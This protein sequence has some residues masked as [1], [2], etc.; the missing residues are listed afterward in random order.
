[1]H[2]RLLRAV[3]AMTR[4]WLWSLVF[5]LAARPASALESFSREPS[6]PVLVELS[7]ARQAGARGCIDRDALAAAVETR[8]G[9]NVFVPSADAD[10]RA[11]VTASIAGRGFVLVLILQNRSGAR[12]GVRRLTTRARHCSALDDSL[13][14]VLALAVDLRRDD[15]RLELQPTQSSAPAEPPAAI[16][17]PLS[18]PDDTL[19]RRLPVVFEPQLGA[20]LAFGLLPGARFGADLSLGIEWPHFWPL[21]LGFTL[22][23]SARLGTEQ[24]LGFSA[25]G[26]RLAV[27][28]LEASFA[29]ARL[30][31]C[32]EHDGERIDAHGFGF[33]RNQPARGLVPLL[34]ARARASLDLEPAFLSLSGA[35][36]VPLLERRYF[37]AQGADV[38]LY[39]TPSLLGMLSLSIG[40][41]W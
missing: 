25:L 11:R 6:S 30:R 7:V 24:G 1:L 15:P 21:E 27:C 2:H 33:D 17:T 3:A 41:R 28:P 18:I 4:A 9:R 13:A 40:V 5:L 8:L 31:F 14:L 34:G 12:I 35:L 37:Y 32:A 36:L 26:Y 16:A 22:W 19:P 39:D 20:A 38:T 10:L 23:Q 29:P